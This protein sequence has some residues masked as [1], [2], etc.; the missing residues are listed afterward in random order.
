METP[1]PHPHGFG[2][3]AFQWWFFTATW[4]FMKCLSRAA[5]VALATAGPCLSMHCED[6]SDMDSGERRYQG[7]HHSVLCTAHFLSGTVRAKALT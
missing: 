2:P 6:I 3:L 5:S 7:S 4:H 1:L